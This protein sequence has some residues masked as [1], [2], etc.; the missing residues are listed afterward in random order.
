LFVVFVYQGCFFFY[1]I[2][3]NALNHPIFESLLFDQLVFTF[4]FH[5]QSTIIQIKG[6]LF[7]FVEFDELGCSL[8]FIPLIVD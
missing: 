5:Q 1:P 2:H 8:F 4:Q 3:K 6:S 7:L